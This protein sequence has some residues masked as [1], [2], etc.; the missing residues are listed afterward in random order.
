MRP[1]SLDNIDPSKYD[2]IEIM[3]MLSLLKID[4]RSEEVGYLDKIHY[5]L[6]YVRTTPWKTDRVDTKWDDIGDK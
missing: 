1:S 5:Q 4:I 3:T 6:R 2:K